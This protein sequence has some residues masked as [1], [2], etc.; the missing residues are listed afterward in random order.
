MILQGNQ[1]GG[2]KDLALHL[3]K[4]E[5][6]HVEVHEIRGFASDNLTGALN[7]AYAVSRGTKCKQFLY[8]L[9]LNPPPKETVSTAE[10]EEV[11]NRAEATLGLNGQPRAIVFHEKEGRRHAH[12][13]WSRIDIY[14]MK[15]V[16]MSYDH[17]KLESLSREIFI[18]RGWDMP[19]GFAKRSERNPKNFTLDEWQQAKRNHK[20]PREIKTAIQDAWAISDGKAAF[21]HALEERGYKLARGDRGRFVA[22][23]IFGEPYSIPR[24]L[25]GVNTKQ[26]R[27]RLGDGEDLPSVEDAKIQ[28][29]QGMSATMQRFKVELA[30]QDKKRRKEAQKEKDRLVERQRSERAAFAQKLRQREQAEALERQAR[31]RKGL[32][33]LWDRINGQHKQISRQNELEAAQAQKRDRTEKDQMIENQLA[34][35]RMLKERAAAQRQS[36]EQQKR[37]V[38]TDLSRF[39]ELAQGNPQ[40]KLEEF[41]RSRQANRRRAPPRDRG[42]ER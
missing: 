5:N 3:V 40:S 8:S 15:A 19:E 38:Q 31:F 27:Q 23:D 4:D 21:S 32:K 41:K 22:V 28:I 7:E 17:R 24:Q 30:E 16:Q 25:H 2:A 10:F 35:R 33:G 12:A 29:G 11:I 36:L 42:P 13:V 37:E 39:N 14:R 6:D 26:V 34:Q 18:E 20:D 1:R 9:S